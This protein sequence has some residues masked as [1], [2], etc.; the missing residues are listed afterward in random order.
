MPTNT[1]NRHRDHRDGAQPRLKVIAEG[2]ETEEQAEFLKSSGCDAVQGYHYGRPQAAD[3]FVLL[4]AQRGGGA[5]S[6]SP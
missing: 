2:V 6:D 5:S 4:L 1:A 3:Q